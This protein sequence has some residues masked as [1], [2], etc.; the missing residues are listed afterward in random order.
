MSEQA[1]N[2]LQNNSQNVNYFSYEQ[3]PQPINS[4]NNNNNNSTNDQQINNSNNSNSNNPASSKVSNNSNF[5]NQSYQ[6][7][8]FKIENYKKQSRAGLENLGD[9]S[10]LNAVLQLLG[11]IPELVEFYINRKNEFY[12][13]ENNEINNAI[14]NRPLSFVTY[15][16]F[17]HLYPE[18]LNDVEKYK[19]DSYLRILSHFNPIYSNYK[20]KNPNDLLIFILNKLDDEMKYK[21]I[22]VSNNEYYGNPSISEEQAIISKVF[23]WEKITTQKCTQCK[24]PQNNK[25][26]FFN[27]FDL[28]ISIT[29]K[30]NVGKKNE[31]SINDCLDTYTTEKEVTFYCQKCQQYQKMLVLSKINSINKNIIF[32]LDRGDDINNELLNIKF[33]IEEKIDLSKYISDEQSPK[34]FELAGIIS[35]DLDNNNKF[36][37]D[38]KSPIDKKWYNFDDVKV[39]FNFEDTEKVIEENNKKKLIPYILYYKSV[40]A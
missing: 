26:S 16:L 9:T 7:N 38:C 40:S 31:I 33:K 18:N 20:R 6:Q 36:V 1:N 22:I 28:D 15:R 17:L 27:T 19:P 10:Y 11:Q 2:N 24:K 5:S 39:E 12:L 13:N 23:R 34:K 14:K 8:E 37:C 25:L 4:Y 30:N 32:L 35:I 21:N 29:W 3:N